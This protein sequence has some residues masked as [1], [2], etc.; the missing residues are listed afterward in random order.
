M[1]EASNN[2]VG[3]SFLGG[4]GGLLVAVVGLAGGL[5]LGTA[6]VWLLGL[7]DQAAQSAGV[8]VFTRLYALLAL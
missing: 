3:P 4:W 2:R 1:S 6:A 5:F 7:L 8:P